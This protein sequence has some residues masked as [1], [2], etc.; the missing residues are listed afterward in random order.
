MPIIL[1]GAINAFYHDVDDSIKNEAAAYLC[2]H[3]R[4]PFEEPQNYVPGQI[5]V[6]KTYVV[7]LEDR[8]LDPA[9]QTAAA[10]AWGAKKVELQ[11]G[12]SPFLKDAERKIVV[13]EIVEAASGG[14]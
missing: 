8:A 5:K 9:Y 11:C 12:H 7:C 6:P 3:S 1:D 13:R 14:V 4:T 10:D 2:R